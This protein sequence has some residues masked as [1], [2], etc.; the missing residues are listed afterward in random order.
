MF[1]SKIDIRLEI[2][3]VRTCVFLNKMSVHVKNWKIKNQPV[4]WFSLT[5]LNKKMG[6]MCGRNS[7]KT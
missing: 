5:E 4:Y 6:I 1:S 2:S 3:V 7:S